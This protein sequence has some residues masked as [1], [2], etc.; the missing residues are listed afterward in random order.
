MSAAE[1]IDA[2][3]DQPLAELQRQIADAP[4]V[5][6]F[7]SALQ[8]GFGLI[9]EIKE[10]SPVMAAMRRANVDAAPQAY[11]ACATVRGISV[12]T[13]ATHFGMSLERLRKTELARQSQSC[14][15]ISSSTITRF[16]KPVLSALTPFC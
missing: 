14:A 7:Q 15:K 16:S 3:R 8:T 9:A 11:E 13:N 5:R 1:L 10:C 2:Q 6:S 12:L 4:P